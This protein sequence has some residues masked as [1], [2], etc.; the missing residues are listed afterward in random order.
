[1]SCRV[2]GG[3]GWER[4]VLFVVG[5]LRNLISQIKKITKNILYLRVYV[6]R[7]FTECIL[8]LY[9]Y[10]FKLVIFFLSSEKR[11]F[12]MKLFSHI[13]L[14]EVRKNQIHEL[15]IHQKL[16]PMN[17]INAFM[18]QNGIHASA[19]T[20]YV[21]SSLCLIQPNFIKEVKND[22]DASLLTPEQHRVLHAQF[23][24]GNSADLARQM[25]IAKTEADIGVY[26]DLMCGNKKIAVGLAQFAFDHV[27]LVSCNNVKPILFS[28]HKDYQKHGLFK[29]MLAL[30][31]GVALSNTTDQHPN[32][33]VCIP[34]QS[35]LFDIQK[36]TGFIG[37]S[38]FSEV[39]KGDQMMIAVNHDTF[40]KGV[41]TILQDVTRQSIITN[42][43]TII[44]TQSPEGGP[45]QYRI[46]QRLTD[47]QNTGAAASN[48]SVPPKAPDGSAP[49]KASDDSAPP[50][51]PELVNPT[52]KRRLGIKHN[53]N[54]LNH[55]P[56]FNVTSHVYAVCKTVAPVGRVGLPDDSDDDYEVSAKGARGT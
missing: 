53:L 4:H 7:I 38:S 17:A 48:D 11:T 3:R 21:G 16:T 47:L 12:Y 44:T 31:T 29:C 32:V 45:S 54:T 23:G 35:A 9:V 5:G 19:T 13:K 52:K 26:I 22:I 46:Q 55:A 15:N 1:M 28:V 40:Q 27:T 34:P 25:V 56:N 41:D 51:A 18:N 50:K 39:R 43:Q 37:K 14:Q 20:W 30:M 24:V 10:I 49:P 6:K 8:V 33:F 42:L 2:R 36:C